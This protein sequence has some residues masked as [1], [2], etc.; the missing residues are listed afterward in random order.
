MAKNRQDRRNRPKKGQ[1]PLPAQTETT[2]ADVAR[3][4]KSLQRAP[5]AR[6]IQTQITNAPRTMRSRAA[7]PVD[8]A[9]SLDESLT[10]NAVTPEADSDWVTDQIDE[11]RG[12]MS[13]IEDKV[14]DRV[15]DRAINE[16][17]RT[18]VWPA[19][20][21]FLAVVVGLFVWH[22]QSLQ[23]VTA[24]INERINIHIRD[25][26]QRTRQ[27]IDRKIEKA[28]RE[29]VDSFSTRNPAPAPPPSAPRH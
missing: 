3:S 23:G 5:Q 12:Q 18:L 25:S 17:W 29:I 14:V 6:S 9:P 22:S 2:A 26:E 13:G 21:V 15:K 16:V 8:S 1:Q 7:V 10:P 24:A 28:K 4:V 27:E 19:V 20:F 11:L